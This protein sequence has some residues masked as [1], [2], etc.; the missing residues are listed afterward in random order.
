[1]TRSTDSNMYAADGR[2]ESQADL[3][4]H[5]G[6]EAYKFI[7]HTQAMLGQVTAHGYI[8]LHIRI[9]IE[10]H[11]T[12]MEPRGY[13]GDRLNGLMSFPPR[14]VSAQVSSMPCRYLNVINFE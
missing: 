13:F 14:T 5:T 2:P 1:M 9:V 4:T 10:R 11:T 3:F 8:V 6:A 7:G 12:G